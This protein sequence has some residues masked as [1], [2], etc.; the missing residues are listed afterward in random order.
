[1]V[2]FY[3]RLPVAAQLSLIFKHWEHRKL[4]QYLSSTGGIKWQSHMV[5][6]SSS[7]P[8]ADVESDNVKYISHLGK[9]KKR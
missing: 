8:P 3:G 2:R 4:V 5:E 1:M 6:K 7:S 9:H